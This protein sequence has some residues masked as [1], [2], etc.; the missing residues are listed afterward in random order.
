MNSYYQPYGDKIFYT[1]TD[2]IKGKLELKTGSELGDMKLEK[3][4]FYGYYRAPK[5]Y[6]EES[7]GKTEKHCKGFPKKFVNELTLDHFK[8][9]DL[10]FSQNKFATLRTSLIRHKEFLSMVDIK[11]ATK[12]GYTKRRIMP[13]GETEPWV[14]KEGKILNVTN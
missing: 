3:E 5:M 13:H 2:C 14:I 1:D 10:F 6:Y 12:S 7:Q 9:T 11:K 8:H 4:N